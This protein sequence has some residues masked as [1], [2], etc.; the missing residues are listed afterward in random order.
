MNRTFRTNLFA[1]VRKVFRIPRDVKKLCLTYFKICLRYFKIG[2]TY[3]K[4][5]ALFF[6]AARN[7]S[8]IQLPGVLIHFGFIRGYSKKIPP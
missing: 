3:F 1:P 2:L 8:L 4:T 7:G 5:G 6:F